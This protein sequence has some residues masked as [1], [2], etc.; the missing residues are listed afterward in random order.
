MDNLHNIFARNCSVRRIDKSVATAFLDEHHRLGGTG[1][2][3]RYGLFVRRSTG[4]DELAM[5]EG[6]L[7]A[8]AVF[9][10]ARRW[11]KG[12]R[13]VA[14]YEWI[15]Y[16]SPTGIRVTGGMGKMLRTFIDEVRPDDVMTY[17][18][19]SWPDRGA[20]YSVLGFKSEGLVER[21]S[22]TCEKFRLKLTDY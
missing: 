5:P 20:V 12:E 21:G 1:G 22:F 16:A 3:Y 14:S 11:Q 15:R 17:A 6:T 7:V 8:V 2:R 18:D 13:R 19:V 10:N 4:E 9:S